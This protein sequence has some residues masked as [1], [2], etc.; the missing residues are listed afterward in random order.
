MKLAKTQS[1][2]GT[3]PTHRAV[4]QPD[5]QSA[6]VAVDLQNDFFPGG[7]LGVQGADKIIPLI[8]KCIQLFHT[9]GFP[10]VATRDWHPP[11]HCS[12]NEQ[13]GAW[14]VHCIQGSRGAQLHSDLV[15]P[16]GTMVISKGTDPKKDAYS[17][18]EGTSLGDRFEDLGVKTL[19]VLGLA[20]DYCV[21]HTVLDACKKGFQVVVIKDA[22]R[23]VEAQIGDSEKAL[24]DMC[25][26]GAIK[27]TA[28]D[29][30][31]D[32]SCF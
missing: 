22:I 26:S 17:G 10:V 24:H 30:G 11:G 16:P 29:L 27:A 1:G 21:K 8:N 3:K 12:F 6:L 25:L 5:Q 7:A 2:T 13:G 19:F 28:E 31:I 32:T 15:M 18:F 4:P 20:T 14:P 23:G 9:L